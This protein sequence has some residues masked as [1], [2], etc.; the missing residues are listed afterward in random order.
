[1]NT[2]IQHWTYGYGYRP[3]TIIM[4]MEMALPHSL[5]RTYMNI[6]TREFKTHFYVEAPMETFTPPEDWNMSMKTFRSMT[7][8]DSSL[9]YDTE[10]AA[11]PRSYVMVPSELHTDD[12]RLLGLSMFDYSTDVLYV[13]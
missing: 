7:T 11:R 5:F 3:E 13:V 10:V 6:D 4:E 9:Y 12:P 8:L 2:D 1:M